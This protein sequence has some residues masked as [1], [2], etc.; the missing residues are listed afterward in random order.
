MSLKQ[1]VLN[2]SAAVLPKLVIDSTS[3][4]AASID[5]T[6]EENLPEGMEMSTVKS[7]FQYRDDYVAGVHHAL[8]VKGAEVSATNKELSQVSLTTNILNDSL[9]CRIARERVG[10]NPAKPGE[11]VVTP[12]A[13]SNNYTVRGAKNVG[14]LKHVRTEIS[15]LY[16]ELA[17]A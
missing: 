13:S 6:F 9:T 4:H 17:N 3:G 2:I 16:R 12:G 11:K 7:V 1:S 8:G 15:D 14:Q 10:N 5:E